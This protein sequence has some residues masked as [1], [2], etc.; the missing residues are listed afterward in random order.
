VVLLVLLTD[1]PKVQTLAFATLSNLT[2]T[3]VS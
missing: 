2:L 1:L 3:Q